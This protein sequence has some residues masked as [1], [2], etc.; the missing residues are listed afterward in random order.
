MGHKSSCETKSIKLLRDNKGGDM[1]DPGAGDALLN[2][3]PKVCA[4]KN[5]RTDRQPG[6]EYLQVTHLT[7]DIYSYI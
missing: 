2:M 4:M 5:I 3:A 6:I 1:H 7:K